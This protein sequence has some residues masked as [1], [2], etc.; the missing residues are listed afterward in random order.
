MINCNV[1]ETE[2]FSLETIWNAS[3][4]ISRDSKLAFKNANQCLLPKI[5]QIIAKKLNIEDRDLNNIISQHKKILQIRAN[6]EITY[7]QNKLNEIEKYTK[8]EAI[9]ALKKETKLEEKIIAINSFINNL[10]K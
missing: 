3:Q 2:N 1:K 4:L 8:E 7:C 9:N 5:N 6:K 10:Q